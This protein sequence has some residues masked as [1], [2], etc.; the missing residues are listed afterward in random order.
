MNEHVYYRAYPLDSRGN[1]AFSSVS[2]Q[3]VIGCL[4]N[5]Y[6][7]VHAVMDADAFFAAH[8]ATTRQAPPP[9]PPDTPSSTCTNESIIGS[10]SETAAVKQ[11]VTAIAVNQEPEK[12][13]SPEVSSF[14]SDVKSLFGEVD[15]QA[16][17]VIFAT[18]DV[19]SEARLVEIA[20]KANDAD[21]A[22]SAA[23]ESEK[24]VLLAAVRHVLPGAQVIKLEEWLSSLS[25]AGEMLPI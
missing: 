24:D 17:L 3:C 22:E 8:L 2:F 21:A 6:V 1:V 9:N 20:N 12:V 23:E 4:A 14:C 19:T 13:E 18:Y 11:E 5:K 10:T 7:P 15:G 16:L 25:E